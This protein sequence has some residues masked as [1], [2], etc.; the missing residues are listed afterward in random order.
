MVL[1][2]LLVTLF[3]LHSGSAAADRPYTSDAV[4]WELAP[5]YGYRFGGG[6][7]GIDDYAAA[8]LDLH[9]APAYGALLEFPSGHHT[10]WQIFYSRQDTEVDVRTAMFNQTVDVTIDYLHFGGTY[11][12]EGDRQRPFVGFTLGATHL[13]PGSGYDDKVEFSFAFVG[14]IKFRLTQRLGLRFDA[15]ALGTVTDS[16]G[17]FFCNGGCVAQFQGGGFWQYDFSLGLN[18]YL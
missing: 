17:G 14:G 10:Q 6:F 2:S 11:V 18:L 7:E 1:R 9:N 5:F 16:Q 12:M 3:L 13:K 8:D 4:G 15:R